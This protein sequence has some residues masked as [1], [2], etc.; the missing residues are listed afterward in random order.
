MGTEIQNNQFTHQNIKPNNNELVTRVPQWVWAA[1]PVLL[2]FFVYCGSFNNG[3]VNWDDTTYIQPNPH[4]HGISISNLKWIFTTT[5]TGNWIPLTWLSL[6]MDYQI[7]GSSLWIYHLD[8]LFLHCLSTFFVFKLIYKILS[9]VQNRTN[10]ESQRLNTNWIL[11]SAF[12]SSLVF[13]LHPIHV[14][15]VVWISDRTDL[16]SGL[17]FFICLITYLEYTEKPGFKNLKYLFCFIWFLLALFAKSN[18]VT[19]PLIFLVI[20]IWILKRFK[21]NRVMVLVKKIPFVLTALMFGIIAIQAKH[22]NLNSVSNDLSPSYRLMNAFHTVWFYLVKLIVPTGLVPLYPIV[23]SKTFSAGYIFSLFTVVGI[24]FGCF[25]YRKRSPSLMAAWL[26][27]LITLIPTVGIFHTGY[28]AT[29]DRYLYLPILG[30]IT[31]LA[32][33]LVRS[34]EKMKSVLLLVIILSTVFLSYRTIKQTS[35]WKN[36]ITLWENTLMI[37]PN[38]S[39]VAYANMG[40]AYLTAGR[41]DEAFYFF[42]LAIKRTPGLSAGHDGLG[43]VLIAQ[44]KLDE[45]II[46]FKQSISID[47]KSATPHNDLG[48]VYAAKVK[49]DEALVECQE[50]IRIDPDFAEAYDNMGNV[51]GKMSK[52]DDSITA[53]RAAVMLEPTNSVYAGHLSTALA[54]AGK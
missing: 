2:T 44:G 26:F 49:Y 7:G 43:E 35:I 36:S 20:D 45:A 30:P 47:S 39:A 46:E 16:L 34:L 3:F 51:Y 31:V 33:V 25:A 42:N 13:G 11:P 53:Y 21:A 28:Q 38:N 1:I 5:Y 17:L 50:A 54:L 8:N 41:I 52:S 12:F 48:K 29:A 6:A 9:L 40:D 27:Y 14:E 4:L 32:V 19:L 18:V 22:L 15:S 37:I 10:L 23:F 24:S